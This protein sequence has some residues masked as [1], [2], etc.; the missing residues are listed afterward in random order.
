MDQIT[1]PIVTNIAL[2]NW[3]RTGSFRH[4]FQPTPKSPLHREVTYVNDKQNSPIRVFALLEYAS[5]DPGYFDRKTYTFRLDLN[6][7]STALQTALKDSKFK[8]KAVGLNTQSPVILFGCDSS[9]PDHF[10][11]FLD[12]LEVHCPDF[13]EIKMAFRQH[14][15]PIVFPH[16]YLK[17]SIIFNQKNL[18]QEKLDDC[19]FSEAMLSEEEQIQYRS[20]CCCLTHQLM[21][22]P[23]YDPQYPQYQYEKAWILEALSKKLENPCNRKPLT[24]EQLIPN[25]ELRQ[26]I[27]VFVNTISSRLGL[28][29]MALPYTSSRA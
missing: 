3:R 22:D 29:L 6:E 21:W 18:N 14:V 13:S 15:R 23:V 2:S 12:F 11:E 24:E 19:G 25:D 28:G 9:K 4:L 5:Y 10:A 16:G 8:I 27:E 26:A 1:R 17:N 20:Y 7:D